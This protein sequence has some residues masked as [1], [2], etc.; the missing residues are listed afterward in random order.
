MKIKLGAANLAYP[1]PVTVVGAIVNGRANFINIAHVGILSVKG[2]SQPHLI[3]LGM[4]KTH[5]TNAGI[6]DAKSFSVNLLSAT[7][8]IEADYV[9]LVSGNSTDKSK[10]FEVFYGELENAPLIANCPVSMECRLYDIYDTPQ[11][12]IFIGEIVASYADEGVMADGRVDISKVD[13]LL[14]DMSSIKYWSL[15]RALG[16]CWDEGKKYRPAK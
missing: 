1:M 9:G 15:G 8:M 7:Q 16:K 6:K 4:N 10:V 2:P 12:D 5:H 14:F 11:H 3:S 13:P